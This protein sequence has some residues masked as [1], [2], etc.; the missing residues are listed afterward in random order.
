MR[1]LGGQRPVLAVLFATPHYARRAELLVDSVQGELGQ[2][3]L[4]GCVAEWV[5]G[6]RREV[7]TGP[8]VS[9]WVA[10]GTGPVETFSMQYVRARGG[11]LFGGYRFEEGSGAHLMICDPFTFPAA[12][13]LEHLNKHVPGV[14]VIGGMASGGVAERRSQLFLDG[15]VLTGGAVGA[16]IAGAQLDLMVSQGCRPI[17]NPYTVTRAEGNVLHELGGRAPVQRLQELV[18]TLP[19]R[20]RELLANGGLHVGRVIDEYRAEQGYGDFL[21]RSVVGADAEA[22][23][24]VVGD[25]IE[26]GQTVQFHV[27]RL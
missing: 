8:G 15:R 4:I 1:A 13:L 7:E 10:A 25:E 22:G 24:I 14:T 16:T 2:V 3:P 20:D 26:V 18:T 23:A 9:L 27:A 5:I 12:E 19:E 21:I 11:G 17:G 6:G